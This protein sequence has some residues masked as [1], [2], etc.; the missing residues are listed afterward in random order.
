M[1]HNT[2]FRRYS[3]LLHF[4]KV[5]NSLFFSVFSEWLNLL[6]EKSEYWSKSQIRCYYSLVLFG[7]YIAKFIDIEIVANTL[8]IAWTRSA[9]RIKYDLCLLNVLLCLKFSGYSA[10]PGINRI[11]L[12][13]IHWCNYIVDDL[14][15]IINTWNT[16]LFS[17]VSFWRAA[18][19]KEK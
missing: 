4:R 15:E 8:I 16:L 17:N 10:L 3:I 19:Q 12:F 6:F 18:I 5:S 2:N 13:L 1:P 14:S 7:N 9:C 11:Q